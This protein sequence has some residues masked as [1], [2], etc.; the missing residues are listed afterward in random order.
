MRLK[1]QVAFIKIL[2]ESVVMIM[3][4]RKTGALVCAVLLGV[5]PSDAQTAAVVQQKKGTKG[6]PVSPAQL[7][8]EAPVWTPT[9]EWES[10]EPSPS[11]L[12]VEQ[13]P[14]PAPEDSGEDRTDVSTTKEPTKAPISIPVVELRANDIKMTIG[15]LVL[16]LNV[17]SQQEMERCISDRI[18][19][20]I[21]DILGSEQV[22]NL[23]MSVSLVSPD[24]RRGLAEDPIKDEGTIAFDTVIRIQSMVTT[25]NVDRYTIGSFNEKTEKAAFLQSLKDTGDPAFANLTYVSVGSSHVILASASHSVGN[26]T[27][28]NDTSGVV[29]SIIMAV[30]AVVG[31]IAAIAYY[32]RQRQKPANKEDSPS[33]KMSKMERGSLAASKKGI[34]ETTS[35]DLSSNSDEIPSYIPSEIL[36]CST[37]SQVVQTPD[38]SERSISLAPS[39]EMKNTSY[40]HVVDAMSLVSG[41]SMSFDFDCIFRTDDS[42]SKAEATTGI[43]VRRQS[44]LT[45]DSNEKELDD[46]KSLHDEK[47]ELFKSLKIVLNESNATKLL[48]EDDKTVESD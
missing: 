6:D 12:P 3:C 38:N 39:D 41:E 29:L 31:A 33:C 34:A 30:V 7:Y 19:G 5:A 23:D 32:R 45:Y 46:P 48:N 44:S 27:A 24:E 37:R 43:F 36:Y 13:G 8:S 16:P 42:S 28:S 35:M 17:I 10:S 26:N 14:S 2:V 47:T 20:S 11:I 22:V 9:T 21:L 4:R 15:G 40:D 1:K 25:H 18:A